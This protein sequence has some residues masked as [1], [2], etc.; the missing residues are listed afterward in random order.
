VLRGRS[1]RT[2][3]GLDRRDTVTPGRS[4]PM[5]HPLKRL[6]SFFVFTAFNAAK[7]A[8]MKVVKVKLRYL[9]RMESSRTLHASPPT[10][11]GKA[12]SAKKWIASTFG[13]IVS[14]SVGDDPEC[15]IRA[16]SCSRVRSPDAEGGHRTSNAGRMNGRRKPGEKRMVGRDV[17]EDPARIARGI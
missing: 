5:Q 11:N 7:T 1:V 6:L 16:R 9:Q 17:V 12:N 2:I 3:F 13:A 4:I 10:E 8:I 14:V 15:P